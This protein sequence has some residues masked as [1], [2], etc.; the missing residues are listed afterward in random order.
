MSMK[1]RKIYILLISVYFRKEQNVIEKS[2]QTRL[3]A[4]TQTVQLRNEPHLLQ[5][6]VVSLQDKDQGHPEFSA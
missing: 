1:K 3:C 4:F 6:R 2:D 5:Q